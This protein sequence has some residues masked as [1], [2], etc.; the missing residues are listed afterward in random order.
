MIVRLATEN[1]GWGYRR[2][3]GELLKLGREVSATAIRATLRRQRVPPGPRRGG[4]TWGAFLRGQARGVLACDFFAVETVRLQVLHVLFFIE[5]RTRAVFVAGCTEHPTATW[6]TQQA[7]HVAWDLAEAGLRP[8]LLLRDRDARFPPS[9]DAVFA[10]EG[11]RVVRTPVRAPRANAIAERWVGTVRRECLDRLL[12]L[13]RRHL[14][15]ILR[16]FVDHYNAA[17]PHRA[18]DLRPPR[19]GEHPAHVAGEVIRRD[20]L[21][22]LIHE[23]ARHVA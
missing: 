23:Y 12:I 7:R 1:P 10:S 20:R 16:E 15:A 2:I 13:G 17:R 9:F 11:L 18:L 21:G 14:D 3:R 5:L 4:L 22:G 8:S 6:V 19:A